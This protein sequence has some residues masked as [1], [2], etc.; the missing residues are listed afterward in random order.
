MEGKMLSTRVF[1][2]CIINP[3]G[4]LRDRILDRI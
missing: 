3:K 2:H 1:L 4:H